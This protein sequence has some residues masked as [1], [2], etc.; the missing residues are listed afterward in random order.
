[1]RWF[2]RQAAFG[3]LVAAFNQYYKS[4]ICDDFLKISSEKLNVKGNVY[5][6]FEAYMNYRNDH[7]KIFEKEYESTFHEY[8]YE[9]LEEKENYINNKLGELPIHKLL[10]QLR[11]DS[12]LWDFDGVSLYPSAMWD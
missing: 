11:L 9:D 2:V 5:D 3:G 7:F 8:R 4:K 10:Q 12:L 6:F 1:M